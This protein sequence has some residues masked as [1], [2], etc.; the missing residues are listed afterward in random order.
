M[1]AGGVFAPLMSAPIV[2]HINYFRGGKGDGV[3]VLAL[4]IIAALMA[5]AQAYRWLLAVG[6]ACTFLIGYAFAD[7]LTRLLRAQ[8]ALLAKTDSGLGDALAS[9]AANSMQLEWG[10]L[11]LVVGA[12]LLLAAGMMGADAKTDESVDGKTCPFCAEVIKKEAKVCRFCG[13]DLIEAQTAPPAPK[14][15]LPAGTYVPV[16]IYAQK[17]N[18]DPAAAIE[19]IKAGQINGRLVGIRWAVHRSELV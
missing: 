16:E 4:A 6:A 1:I 13:R 11:L 10:W 3:F 8:E 12:I 14:S 7:H 17:K 2:G 19:A 18:I 5:A 15:N 9:L